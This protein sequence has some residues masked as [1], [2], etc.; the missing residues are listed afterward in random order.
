MTTALSCGVL[1]T[2]GH[3]LLIGHAT[4]SPRWDI[5]KGLADPGEDPEMAARRELSEETGLHAPT[6]VF[7]GRHAYRPKKDLA[8]YLWQTDAMPDPALLVCRSTFLIAG[9]AYPEFDRFDCPPWPDAMDRVGKS[10]ATVLRA[11]AAA[12]GWEVLAGRV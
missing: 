12:N 3:H 4:R 7:L 2:D 5:P 11:I 9:T 8:L 1:V 10:M 6:L